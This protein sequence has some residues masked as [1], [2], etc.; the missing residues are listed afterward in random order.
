MPKVFTSKSQKVGELGESLAEKYLVGKGYKI[1]ERNYTISQG[2]IDIVAKFG[3][4]IVFVEVKAVSVSSEYFNRLTKTGNTESEVS[5]AK[6]LQNKGNAANTVPHETNNDVTHVTNQTN[7]HQ[8]GGKTDQFHKGHEIQIRPEDNLHPR[9]LQK[10]Y[11]TIEIYL[12]DKSVLYNKK[13][14]ID[15]LC[16]FLDIHSKQARVVQYENVNI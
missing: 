5:I 16:V 14:R 2:E 1:V 3:D 11:R 4:S 9:K 13:W 10:L 12:S 8:T 15:L 6:T 7:S